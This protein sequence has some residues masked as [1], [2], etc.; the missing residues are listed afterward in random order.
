MKTV[1]ILS[2][3]IITGLFGCEIIIEEPYEPVIEVSGFYEVDEWSETIEAQ[4]FYEVNIYRDRFSYDGIYIDNFY[5]AGLRVYAEM[6][7]Y[8]IRIPLQRIGYYEIEGFGSYCLK[9]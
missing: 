9:Y 8:K 7:G 5:N 3:L 4:S 1:H 6:N 2:L